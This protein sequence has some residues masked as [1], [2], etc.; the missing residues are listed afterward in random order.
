MEQTGFIKDKYPEP[1]PRL[2]V[3]PLL[4]L[5]RLG[6]P[7]REAIRIYSDSVVIR[8]LPYPGW[9]TFERDLAFNFAVLIR[10]LG[11]L[12]QHRWR[13]KL[14]RLVL[15]SLALPNKR[16]APLKD[17][18][19]LSAMVRGRQM[20]SLWETKLLPAWKI[21]KRCEGN[22]QVMRFRLEKLHFDE[23]DI[24]AFLNRRASP[25]SVLALVYSRRFNVALGTARNAL[26]EYCLR[27]KTDLICTDI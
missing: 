10:L 17:A 27:T 15:E 19:L 25:R 4:G 12:P 14:L 21:R 8:G 11:E 2:N 16:G 24:A 9:E 6:K 7:F 26:R 1:P 23:K 5:G 22:T 13:Q 20:A 18:R 3:E